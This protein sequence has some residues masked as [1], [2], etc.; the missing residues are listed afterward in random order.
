MQAL[1][2]AKHVNPAM[3][4]VSENLALEGHPAVKECKQTTF[5]LFAKETREIKMVEP[6]GRP[7]RLHCDPFMRFLDVKALCRKL[8]HEAGFQ[9]LASSFLMRGLDDKDFK[10]IFETDDIC[11]DEVNF[12]TLGQIGWNRKKAD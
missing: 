9:N 1:P 8:E 2:F 12:R 11:S 3:A 7:E 5:A 10:R 6:T 4:Q